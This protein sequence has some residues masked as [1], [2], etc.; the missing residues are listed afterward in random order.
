MVMTALIA[1]PNAPEW[2]Q[3][4][5]LRL[6]GAFVESGAVARLQPFKSDALPD[7]V[8]YADSLIAVTD[9]GAP[10]YSDGEFWYPVQL[11]AHL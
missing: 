6:R 1:E 7:P 5:V 4:F 3:R 2:F 11:G 8:R 9:I 10:A